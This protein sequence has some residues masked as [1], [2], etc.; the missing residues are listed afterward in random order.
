MRKSYLLSEEDL[1][2]G[3]GDLAGHEDLTTAGGLVVEQDAIA[4]KHVVRLPVHG[5]CYD[6]STN[7]FLPTL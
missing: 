2:D 1:G 4:C 5:T 3:H 7:V 6:Q